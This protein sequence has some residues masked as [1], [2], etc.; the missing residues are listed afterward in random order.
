MHGG[1]VSVGVVVA[2]FTVVVDI[3]DVLFGNDTDDKLVV[4]LVGPTELEVAAILVCIVSIDAVIDEDVTWPGIENWDIESV[5]I[6]LDVVSMTPALVEVT[7]SNDDA[8]DWLIDW[9]FNWLVQQLVV[10]E[11]RTDGDDCNCVEVEDWIVSWLSAS[12]L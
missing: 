5:G 6:V 8:G 2:G 10:E 12:V 3:G 9:E 1:T 11:A 7:N 4:A